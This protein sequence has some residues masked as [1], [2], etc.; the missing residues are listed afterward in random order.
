MLKTLRV[1]EK[2]KSEYVGEEG[3]ITNINETGINVFV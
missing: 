1:G 3:V 2:I